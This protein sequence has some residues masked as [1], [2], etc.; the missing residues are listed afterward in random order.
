LGYIPGILNPQNAGQDKRGGNH[1][2]PMDRYIGEM[3]H[4]HFSMLYMIQFTRR[5]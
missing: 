5:N 1:V 4:P 3:K 2:C